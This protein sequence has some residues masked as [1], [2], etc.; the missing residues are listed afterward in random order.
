V[1]LVATR[2]RHEMTVRQEFFAHIVVELGLPRTCPTT[3]N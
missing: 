1:P 3:T 2:R